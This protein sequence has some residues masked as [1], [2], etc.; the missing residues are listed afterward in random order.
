M[1]NRRPT[2]VISGS[3]SIGYDTIN[4][5]LYFCTFRIENL[6]IQYYI[7]NLFGSFSLMHFVIKMAFRKQNDN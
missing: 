3:G 6:N 1:K 4:Y 5:K 2:A 7:L